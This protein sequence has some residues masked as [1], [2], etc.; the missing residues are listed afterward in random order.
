L[1]SGRCS[2][3]V[4][5]CRVDAWDDSRASLVV[6]G[7]GDVRRVLGGGRSLAIA[8]GGGDG[9]WSVVVVKARA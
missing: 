1:F 5:H 7:D 9:G 6:N 8:L 4:Y 2:G 3:G